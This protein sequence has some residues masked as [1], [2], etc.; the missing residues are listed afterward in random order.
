MDTQTVE[1]LTW[2]VRAFFGLTM[3][4]IA[5]FLR[6]AHKAFERSVEKLDLLE[7]KFHDHERRLSLVELLIQQHEK[8]L[9]H[10]GLERLVRRRVTD[11]IPEYK[12]EDIKK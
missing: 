11:A 3:G 12:A 4:V 7:T 2:V 8:E 1:L 5:Y 10:Y 9:E 6:Q